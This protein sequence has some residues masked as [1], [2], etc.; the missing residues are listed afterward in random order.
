VKAIILAAGY[1]TRLYPLTEHYPKPLLGVGGSTLLDRLLADIDTID[2]IDEHIIV[3]NHRFIS[4]F[5]D[6]L[7][8]ARSTYRK[9]ITLLDD[10]STTNENRIGAVNDLILAIEQCHIND[11]I[12]VAAADNVLDFSFTGFADYFRRKRTSLIMCH[13]EESIAALQKTGVVLLNENDKVLSMEEKPAEPKTHWAAP[14]F[15]LYKKEDLPLIHTAV[16]NGCNYDA[17]GNLAHYL[18]PRTTLHAWPMPGHRYDIG[19]IASYDHV[20]T[21]FG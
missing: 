15:Y 11:D 6:W 3:T 1:A 5:A 12:L 10:G 19:D 4:I 14:P 13:H 21:L 9:P 2:D 7:L 18:V 8:N 16:T 20:K 17:P